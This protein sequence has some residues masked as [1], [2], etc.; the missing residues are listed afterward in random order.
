LV[1]QIRR[2]LTQKLL[3][4]PWTNPA[5]N[6]QSPNAQDSLDAIGNRNIKRAGIDGVVKQE[7]LKHRAAEGP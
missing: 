5:R 6:A 2:S 4:V 7:I 1:A 3:N